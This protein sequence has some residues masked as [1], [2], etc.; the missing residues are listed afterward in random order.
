MAEWQPNDFGNTTNTI[1]FPDQMRG[2]TIERFP[3]VLVQDAE[4]FPRDPRVPFVPPEIAQAPAPRSRI[5]AFNKQPLT[6][7]HHQPVNAWVP[8]LPGP[9]NTGRPTMI[10]PNTMMATP[11][12]VYAQPGPVMTGRPV[13]NPAH[14]MM[15]SPPPGYA[16]QEPFMGP[17][18][19]MNPTHAM[20]TTPPPVLAQRMRE[21]VNQYKMILRDIRTAS[22]RLVSLIKLVVDSLLQ[23][24]ISAP[25]DTD[26]FNARS[27][28]QPVLRLTRAS[29]IRHLQRYT[30][31][32]Q[33]ERVPRG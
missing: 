1:N 4:R 2:R 22:G 26:L 5:N 25:L 19:A 31:R 30:R 16:Q 32:L 9:V 28:N 33:R 8:G 13:M 21:Q 17:H 3:P 10:P 18:P 11:P 24:I 6:Y 20:M 12:A 29:R 23:S 27:S 14:A 7:Q 15:N